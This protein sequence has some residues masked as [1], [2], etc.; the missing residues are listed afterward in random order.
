MAAKTDLRDGAQGNLRRRRS[1]AETVPGDLHGGPGGAAAHDKASGK[2][3]HRAWSAGGGPLDGHFQMASHRKRSAALE[4]D[5]AGTHVMNGAGTPMG[6]GSLAGH[7][8]PNR[9]RQ[10]KPPPGAP[11]YLLPYF[12]IGPPHP[13]NTVVDG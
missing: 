3:T 12:H 10:S 6:S 13:S 11:L 5:S 9:Q 7:A 8:K 1:D 2:Q 4:T